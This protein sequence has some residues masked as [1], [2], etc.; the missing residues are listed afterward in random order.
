[1]FQ[2]IKILIKVLKMWTANQPNIAFDFEPN[3]ELDIENRAHMWLG[4]CPNPSKIEKCWEC[5]FLSLYAH[6]KKK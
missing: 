5:T 4:G 3:F 1:M 6:V 2:T